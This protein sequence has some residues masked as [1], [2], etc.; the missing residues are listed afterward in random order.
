VR[1]LLGFNA[2]FAIVGRPSI[3][4]AS[5]LGFT[6]P[7]RRYLAEVLHPALTG[8][9]FDVLDPWSNPLS[10]VSTDSL[11]E[12]VT[13]NRSIGRANGVSV[14]RADAVLAVL[15]G[16]D[17]ESGTASEIGYAAACG[18]PVVGLRTDLRASGENAASSIKLQVEYFV[19]ATG[20]S[21]STAVHDAITEALRV[22]GERLL[23]HY[24]LR[25]AWT[26][27]VSSGSYTASTRNASLAEVGF[28]HLSFDRQLDATA[29]RHYADV[30]A[31]ELLRLTVD[32][33]KLSAQLLVEHA[34]SV[35][36]AFPH[37]YGPINL[38]AVVSVS[39]VERAKDGSLRAVGM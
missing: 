9:G 32:R 18:V 27:A 15:D 23:Y 14:A 16:S 3:Y 38:D 35:G 1:A 37:V 28:I 22:V 13:I 7:G 24:A 4:V 5:P 17:V 6:D 11:D 34:P 2:T 31:E 10:T 39:R 8:A 19:A 12:L 20:S 21:M 25:S 36:E 26:D 33:K 30:D 29:R